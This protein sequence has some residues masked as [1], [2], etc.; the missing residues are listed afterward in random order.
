MELIT[1]GTS[2]AVILLFITLVIASAGL[3]LFILGLILKK[4][5]QWVPGIILTVVSIILGIYS[6]VLFG[7]S[8]SHSSYRSNDYSN[9]N[10]NDP[11]ND[12]NDQ[13]S[14]AP[15]VAKPKTNNDAGS[16]RVSG[17]IQDADKSLIYIKIHPAADLYD[18][19][20]KVTKIDT[21]NG[22]GKDKKVI[23]LEI[24]FENK[25]KGNL[26]LILYSSEDVEL[27]SS[28][29]TINQDGNT[30]FTIKF[31]FD[32]TANFLQTD[33]AQLKTSD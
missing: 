22:S 32:K 30:T 3:I 17:F 23:P 5:G 9:Y 10:Y 2:T 12:N 27:G 13:N 18:M 25:F 28:N 19:G 7:N 11:D 1:T 21:Y 6:L 15:D 14:Q 16:S 24:N 33:H 26:Q 8:V 20:I 31:A 29:V 4:P